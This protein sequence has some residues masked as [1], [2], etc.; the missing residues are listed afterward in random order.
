MKEANMNTPIGQTQSKTTAAYQK[1]FGGMEGFEM[2]TAMG[3]EKV[4]VWISETVGT[5][6][7]TRLFRG[8]ALGALLVAATGLYFSI[9]QGEAGSP[10][11]SEQTDV[12]PESIQTEVWL[13]GDTYPMIASSGKVAKAESEDLP[14]FMQT[15]VW[16]PGD[17]YPVAAYSGKVAKA[18]SEDLP[19]F[20]QTEVWYPG[21]TYPVSAYSSKVAGTESEDLPAFLQTEVW[22]P[23]DTYPVAAYSGKVAKAESEDLPAFMQTEVWLPGDAYPVFGR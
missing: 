20:M 17:T 5:R 2:K 6:I 22:L 21:D 11:V 3:M 13:P 7:A 4:K 8:L 15:E 10:L 19:A 16:F 14:A 1:G 9:N 12:Y 23:G 18:E